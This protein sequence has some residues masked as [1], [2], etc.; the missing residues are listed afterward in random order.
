MFESSIFIFTHND[1]NNAF[2]N[3]KN[4]SSHINHNWPINSYLIQQ[5]IRCQK[6]GQMEIQLYDWAENI[7]GKAKFDSEERKQN[8]SLVLIENM[9][10]A[11]NI[12]V[13]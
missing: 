10:F 4:K 5:Y 11:D 12:I 13:V 3:L 9:V 7:V 6:Y 1:F 8:F 2:C